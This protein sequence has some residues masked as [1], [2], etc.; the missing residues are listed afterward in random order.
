MGQKNVFCYFIS[1]FCIIERY[2]EFL[3]FIQ[4]RCVFFNGLCWELSEVLREISSFFF[5]VSEIK[6]TKNKAEKSQFPKFE[7]KNSHP[8]LMQFS[9]EVFILIGYWWTI[10]QICYFILKRGIK[11][12]KFWNFTFFERYD[13]EILIFIQFWCS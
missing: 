1:K 2:K 10:K 3:F 7:K 4:F 6:L 12:P 8:I 5:T 9:C 11:G 13:I